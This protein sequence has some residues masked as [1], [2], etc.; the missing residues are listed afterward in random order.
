MI[1]ELIE[2]S[3]IVGMRNDYVQAGGGNNSV[4]LDNQYMAIKSSGTLLSDMKI[5]S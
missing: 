1:E 4:K 2:I 5:K 3:K